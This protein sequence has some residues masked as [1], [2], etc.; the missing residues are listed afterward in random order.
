[1]VSI[2]TLEIAIKADMAE[3]NQ[4][5]KTIIQDQG[6]KF[7]I[8]PTVD[9]KN[10]V[11]L[12]QH[13]ALKKKDHKDLQKSFDNNP[14][15]P[16]VDLRELESLTKAYQ[17]LDGL[18]NNL[19]SGSGTI[20]FAVE[21]TYKVDV[22]ESN[23]DIASQ[24]KDLGSGL[25]DIVGAVKS[26]KQGIVGKAVGGLIGAVTSTP[27]AI[28]RGALEGVGRES[29]SK[30]SKSLGNEFDSILTP[31]I[32]SMDTLGKRTAKNFASKV[33]KSIG[34]ASDVYDK[35]LEKLI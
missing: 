19:T 26:T 17:K 35:F 2:G 3:Y 27:L 4:A 8:V 18:K 1:M 22:R 16:K 32:G 11:A 9:H 7:H 33:G 29:I 14:L 34:T 6:L 23:R 31:L 10:L 20:H 28:A 5:K 30:L 21:H 25:R 15:T 13:F 24:I 12:N